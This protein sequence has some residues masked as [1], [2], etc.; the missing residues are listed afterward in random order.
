MKM[1]STKFKK[2]IK[3]KVLASNG[4]VKIKFPKQF[5]GNIALEFE[6]GV[7]KLLLKQWEVYLN[8][9]NLEIQK[10]K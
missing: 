4:E 3:C 7:K 1:L 2:T 5:I 10:V 6:N 9:D 8:G